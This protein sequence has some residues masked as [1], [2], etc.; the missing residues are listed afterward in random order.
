M[1]DL[2]ART[3][4]CHHWVFNHRHWILLW[5]LWRSSLHRS[6]GG[7]SDHLLYVEGAVSS[8]SIYSHASWRALDSSHALFSHPWAWHASNSSRNR[9]IA[10]WVSN[11]TTVSMM[12]TQALAEDSPQGKLV[13]I[14]ST[15]QSHSRR[16]HPDSCSS[17]CNHQ[18]S[19]SSLDLSGMI[20]IR[21]DSRH[22]CFR[23]RRSRQYCHTL[24]YIQLCLHHLDKSKAVV[25]LSLM[26]KSRNFSLKL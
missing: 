10:E 7:R 18:C 16:S 22:C 1:I 13:T 26:S 19:R 14:Q 20:R 2:W 17:L 15:S 11:T 5:C 23:W 9:P 21:N 24:I 4:V 6:T 25:C 3:S 12:L 8:P